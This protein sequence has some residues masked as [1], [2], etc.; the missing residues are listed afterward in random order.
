VFGLGLA[1]AILIDATLVRMVLVPSIMEL[2][3]DAN[4]WMPSWLDRMVP[5]LGIEVD[6]DQSSPLRHEETVA[7]AP[8]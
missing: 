6:V 1:A 3:G 2:I 5:H 7:A 8:I 4:W